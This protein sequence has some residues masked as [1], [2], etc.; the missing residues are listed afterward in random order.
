MTVNIEELRALPA[1]E[2]LRLIAIL[3]DDLDDSNQEIS[4]PPWVEQEAQRR[5][6]EVID[7]PSI[8]VSHEEMWRRIR[9]RNGFES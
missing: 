5:R 3:W 4:I 2:K 7:D 1:E 9:E 6:Q 8:L